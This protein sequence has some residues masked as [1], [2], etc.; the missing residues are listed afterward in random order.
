MLG[1]TDSLARVNEEGTTMSET[2]SETKSEA[3]DSPSH[4]LTS[5]WQDATEEGMARLGA[6]VEETQKL[7]GE[8]ARQM[9]TAIDEAARLGKESIET[10][11]RLALDWQRSS[12]DAARR[13]VEFAQRGFKA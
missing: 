4:Q 8:S 3:K 6:M 13:A 5:F 7:Q 9:T 11:S 10:A 2:K 12:L 1:A